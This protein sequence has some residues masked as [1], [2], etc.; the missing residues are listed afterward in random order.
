VGPQ[1]FS[2]GEGGGGPV[3]LQAPVGPQPLVGGGGPKS[4]Q[5]PVGPQ[6]AFS[7]GGS[8]L[9]GL[10]GRNNRLFPEGTAVPTKCWGLTSADRPFGPGARRIVPE[11]PLAAPPL[12]TSP[13]RRLG[14]STARHKDRRPISAHSVHTARVCSSNGARFGTR[15]RFARA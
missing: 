1:P 14:E 7:R 9:L 5:A 3:I 6:S 15:T 8:A 12:L 13:K 10:R 11:R 4:L 2:K